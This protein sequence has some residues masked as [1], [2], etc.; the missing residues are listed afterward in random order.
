MNDGAGQG[1]AS[2]ASRFN[3]Q[4][5]KPTYPELR[6]HSKALVPQQKKKHSNKKPAAKRTTKTRLP[7]G[8]SDYREI[9]YQGDQNGVW[10]DAWHCCCNSGL[11]ISPQRLTSNC[12]FARHIAF[13]SASAKP[14]Q[15]AGADDQAEIEKVT[16]PVR[17]NKVRKTGFSISDSGTGAAGDNCSLPGT[18]EF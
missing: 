13:K 17:I 8:E 12:A 11:L 10:I 16:T 7:A 5:I 15:R 18:D 2:A 6:H 9:K 4:G 14:R 3:G 1:S